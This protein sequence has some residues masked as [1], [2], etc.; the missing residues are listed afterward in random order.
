[1]PDCITKGNA[2]HFLANHKSR[3][4]EDKRSKGGDESDDPLN[5]MSVLQVDIQ[6]F[7]LRSAQLT[8][9]QFDS[10]ASHVASAAVFAPDMSL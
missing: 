6:Y 2:V 8:I 4:R 1:M 3:K 9:S 5:K 10:D 7:N